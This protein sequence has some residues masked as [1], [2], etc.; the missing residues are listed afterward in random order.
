MDFK[1]KS[2]NDWI[3][4]YQQYEIAVLPVVTKSKKI[5]LQ[6]W[7]LVTAPTQK[8]YQK[9]LQQ[10]L[11]QNIAILTGI[12]SNNLMV[13]DID[14]PDYIPLTF[15]EELVIDDDGHTIGFLIKT[16][17]GYQLWFRNKPNLPLYNEGT[18]TYKIDLFAY[19]HIAVAPP[20]I[21][22][23]GYQYTFLKIPPILK[24]VNVNFIYNRLKLYAIRHDPDVLLQPIMN[25]LIRK[26]I[27]DILQD[28]KCDGAEGHKKRLWA[29]GFLHSVCHLDQQQL[30][31]FIDTFTRWS[32][33][34]PSRTKSQVASILR[35]IDKKVGKDGGCQTQ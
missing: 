12:P 14:K 30:C 5:N 28:P 4:F 19:R 10:N 31:E 20:S 13:I 16:G 34:N 6:T 26:K 29:V 9:W 1:F 3:K 11:F 32:D 18:P 2:P 23:N 35:C 27:M 22:P 15:L 25:P 24:P 8:D 33:Y 17:R 7:D 21:H